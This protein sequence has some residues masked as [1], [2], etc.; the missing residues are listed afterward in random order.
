MDFYKIK[1]TSSEKCAKSAKE[2]S[3]EIGIKYDKIIEIFEAA[4]K[5]IIIDSFF[6]RYFSQIKVLF[7]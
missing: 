3:E 7:V 6:R 2:I 5:L 1:V 4:H